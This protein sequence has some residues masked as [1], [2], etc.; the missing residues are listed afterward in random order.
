VSLGTKNC[1]K[2]GVPKHNLLAVSRPYLIRIP[3]LPPLELLHP[4]TLSYLPLYLP[5]QHHKLRFQNQVRDFKIHELQTFA[6]TPRKSAFIN[7]Y[8]II[9]QRTFSSCR[10]AGD[11]LRK[12]RI[13]GRRSELSP[14]WNQHPK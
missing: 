10:T 9:Y 13:R 3:L 6:Q 7:R 1:I 8:L 14:R 12:C 11:Q 5:H 2:I 4:L